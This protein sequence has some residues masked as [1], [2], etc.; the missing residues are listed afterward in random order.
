MIRLIIYHIRISAE[1]AIPAPGKVREAPPP[2]G[3]VRRIGRLE[4]EVAATVLAMRLEDQVTFVRLLDQ[5]DAV[6]DASAT[7]QIGHEGR[8][9]EPLRID[10]MAVAP[11]EPPPLELRFASETTGA[12]PRHGAT[13]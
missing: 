7:D 13:S 9:A 3:Y 10:S 12:S 8:D 2:H 1:L 5:R 6:Q 11:Y 4:P